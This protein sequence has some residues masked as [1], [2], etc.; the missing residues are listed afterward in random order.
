MRPLADADRPWVAELCRRYFGDETVA[1]LGR[2]HRPAALPGLVAWEAGSRRGA[3]C[4][5]EEPAGAEVVLLAADQPGGGIG[6]ALVTALEAL[7]DRVGWPRLRL[8]LTNDNTP[9][10]RFYQRRGW[11]LVALHAGAA[12][13]DRRLKPAIPTLGVDGIPIRHLLELERRSGA[14]TEAG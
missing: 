14:A 4:Y 6:T 1:A 12:E 3:A 7:A 5:R 13:S 8:L 2:L 11:N 10:L 9:A